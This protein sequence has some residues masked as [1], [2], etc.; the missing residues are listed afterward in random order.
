MIIKDHIA[1]PYCDTLYQQV[2]LGK[3]E[4]LSCAVCGSTIDNGV[5]DFQKSLIFALTAVILFIIANTFPFIT[6]ELAGQTNTITI[7]SSLDS[8]FDNGLEVLGVLVFFLI[9]VTPLWY[10]LGVVWVALSFRF[11]LAINVTRHF[12]HW[13]ARLSPWNMLEVYL[14]GV[15]VMI[16]KIMQIANIKFDYGFWAFV[17]LMICSVL[18]AAYFHL[19]DATIHAYSEED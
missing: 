16:V 15:L 4:S 3:G 1:C 14:V 5:A 17:A 2:P 13:M 10:L 19:D 11:N 12:L 18:S 9:I 8:L 7:L 6:I